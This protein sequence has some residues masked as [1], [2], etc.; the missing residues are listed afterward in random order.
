MDNDSVKSEFYLMTYLQP[1][2]FCILYQI[3][4]L[5]IHRFK[6]S[7]LCIIL[8]QSPISYQFLL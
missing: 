1:D 6:G 7:R 8:S 5:N 4:I 2:K 3:V